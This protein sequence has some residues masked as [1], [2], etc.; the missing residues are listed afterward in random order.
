ML[1]VTLKLFVVGTPTRPRKIVPSIQRQAK[2][3][4]LR[5]VTDLLLYPCLTQRLLGHYPPN[6]R[7]DQ[8]SVSAREAV[9]VEVVQQQVFRGELKKYG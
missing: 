3:T 9:V 2:N 1:V 4:S 7:T 5:L 6:E 8:H